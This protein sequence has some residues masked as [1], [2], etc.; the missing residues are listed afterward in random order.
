M[1]SSL[2]ITLDSGVVRGRVDRGLRTWRA[3]PYA[4]PPIGPWRFRAPQAV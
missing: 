1:T 3:I 4:A 2:E